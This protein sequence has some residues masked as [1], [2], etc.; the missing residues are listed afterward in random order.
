MFFKKKSNIENVNEDV[1]LKRNIYY[2]LSGIKIIFESDNK[3]NSIIEKVLSDIEKMAYVQSKEGLKIDEKI[4][5][6]LDDLKEDSLK[7]ISDEEF[8]RYILKIRLNL[9]ERNRYN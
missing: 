3:K 7:G 1:E 6:I 4:S 8:E 2:K 9:D 5:N